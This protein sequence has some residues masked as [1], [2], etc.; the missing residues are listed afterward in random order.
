MAGIYFETDKLKDL[1]NIEL[2]E[3]HKKINDMYFSLQSK[4]I[5]S[6]TRNQISQL[7]EQYTAELE[8]RIAEDLIDED[9]LEDEY[10]D[11]V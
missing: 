8:R 6:E 9:E 5:P 11:F 2:L 7:F 3:K 10:E 4:S 1:S